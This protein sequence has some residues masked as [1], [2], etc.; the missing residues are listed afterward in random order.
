MIGSAFRQGKTFEI[1]VDALQCSI[2]KSKSQGKLSAFTVTL[3]TAS[4][5]DHFIEE[6]L[7]VFQN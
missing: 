1:A 5:V 4:L 7:V 2:P 6:K 3:L